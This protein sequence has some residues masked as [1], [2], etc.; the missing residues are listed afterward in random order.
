ML[1]YHSILYKFLIE[2]YL[3]GY[4]IYLHDSFPSNPPKHDVVLVVKV[5][6]KRKAIFSLT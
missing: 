5:L 2:H 4:P 1:K 3:Y 6:L